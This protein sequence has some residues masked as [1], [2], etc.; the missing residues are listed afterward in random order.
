M[1][2]FIA[3]SPHL[4]PF[5]DR[6]WWRTFESGTS[7]FPLIAGTGTELL[8]SLS[9]S[10]KIQNGTDMVNTPPMSLLFLRDTPL[11]I[12]VHDKT[13]FLS[14]RIRSGM[15]RHFLPGG[16]VSELPPVTDCFDLWG[17]ALNEVRESILNAASEIEAVVYLE[18]FLTRQLNLCSDSNRNLDSLAHL[19][20]YKS[21][22]LTV[23]QAA[24]NYGVSRRQLLRVCRDHFGFSPKEYLT[25]SRFNRALK[26]ML[27]S[28]Q[29]SRPL[30][31]GYFDQ[32]HFIHNCRRFTGMTP[33]FI[34]KN[35][36]A[37]SHF[38]NTSLRASS[39]IE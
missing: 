16:I 22:S 37:M 20:Y 1:H 10:L 23:E 18:R 29:N 12:T 15:L 13:S 28:E 14:V 8:F 2:N 21:E 32:S 7:L 5:I 25:I 4:S 17:N 3:P 34:I 30:E 33:K 31:H 38:Y 24:F 27:L 6:F 35:S 19:L 36:T 11:P 39:Y 9:S 26:S